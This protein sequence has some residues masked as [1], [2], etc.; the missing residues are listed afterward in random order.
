MPAS[1]DSGARR[2]LQR[3][4]LNWGRGHCAIGEQRRD[5]DLGNLPIDIVIRGQGSSR[6][7]GPVCLRT[8]G[9]AGDQP[10]LGEPSRHGVTRERV[11]GAACPLGGVLRELF[12]E[13]PRGDRLGMMEAGRI[14]EASIGTHHGEPR[15]VR[16]F[17][18]QSLDDVVGLHARAGE[19]D[20]SGGRQPIG[21]VGP[22]GR[23]VAD[24][25]RLSPGV[26]AGEEQGCE[27]VEGRASAA[28]DVVEQVVAIDDEHGMTVAGA[29][30]R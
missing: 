16:R 26:T 23:A 4:F 6:G 3:R 24:K 1:P 20:P 28:S 27:G 10:K 29:S 2:G 19:E 13:T 8:V 21:V 22:V 5:V 30:A 11:V 17:G 14:A 12:G 15:R 25:H 18:E 9:V 7:R